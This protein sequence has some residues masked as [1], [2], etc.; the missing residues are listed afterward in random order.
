VTEPEPRIIREV[1]VG[2]G[3]EAELVEIEYE[4]DGEVWRV[5][6]APEG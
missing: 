6:I 5:Y 4:L 1:V 3:D 2:E